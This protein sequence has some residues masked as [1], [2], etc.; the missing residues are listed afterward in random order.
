MEPADPTR[1]DVNAPAEMRYWVRELGRSSI[2]LKEAVKI[3]G[4]L[5]ADVRSHLRRQLLNRTR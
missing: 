3:V 2:Q 4:P 1:I 5:V